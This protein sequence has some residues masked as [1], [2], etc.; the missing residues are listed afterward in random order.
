M[1]KPF[2]IRLGVYNIP[3]FG[4]IDTR[5]EV[6]IPKQI[7]LYLLDAFPFIEPTEEAIPLLKKEKLSLEVLTR[8]VNKATTV[9]EVN[10]LSQ[11][12]TSA[13]FKTLVDHK[14]DSFSF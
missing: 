13:K 8:L 7:Q 9:E 6:S 4:R 2:K 10:I 11:L 12:K 1:S 5:K 3:T 14:L